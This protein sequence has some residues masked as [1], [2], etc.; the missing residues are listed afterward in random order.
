MKSAVV[1]IAFL[2][3]LVPGGGSD[4]PEFRT[5]GV[6]TNGVLLYLIVK[7]FATFVR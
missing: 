3:Y 1:F 4:Y 5:S 7:V 6:R 2:A